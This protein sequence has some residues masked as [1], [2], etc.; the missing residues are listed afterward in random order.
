MTGTITGKIVDDAGKPVGG[1]RITLSLPKC[2]TP[3]K[4]LATTTSD[5]NGV[6]ALNDVAPARDY[7]I[8]VGAGKPGGEGTLLWGAVY[9]VHVAAGKT[10]DVRTIK[11]IRSSEW[12]ITTPR[13]PQHVFGRHRACAAIDPL[14]GRMLLSINR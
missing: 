7:G 14:K 3:G 5:N 12:R 11:L 8:A 10:V 2:A 4:T 1:A 6:F 13:T 9:G